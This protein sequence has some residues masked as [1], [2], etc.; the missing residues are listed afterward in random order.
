[1]NKTD[2]RERSSTEI[3]CWTE[4]PRR[5]PT[6]TQS[7]TWSTCCGETSGRK[8][9]PFPSA[10][11]AI[12]VM[13]AGAPMNGSAGKPARRPP[14]AGPG[15]R[16][17]LLPTRLWRL[18][19]SRRTGIR[20]VPRATRANTRHR[21]LGQLRALAGLLHLRGS[22]FTFA[23]YRTFPTH[24]RDAPSAFRPP[25]LPS[26]AQRAARTTPRRR[27]R[28]LSRPPTRFA[29]VPRTTHS[30]FA[31]VRRVSTAG[32]PTAA[33]P[34]AL[35]TPGNARRFDL[36]NRAHGEQVSQRI[37]QEGAA[38]PCNRKCHSYS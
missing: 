28:G 17:L 15:D 26:S 7:R 11:G 6:I 8:A 33:C 9:R 37:G 18:I 23:T 36:L 31:A 30:C 10:A 27:H 34:L 13:R 32:A 2:P 22:R 35:S 12:T 24:H 3:S 21:P 4:R 29:P 19:Y 16:A 5:P 14:L 1:M 20:D 25:R 38:D